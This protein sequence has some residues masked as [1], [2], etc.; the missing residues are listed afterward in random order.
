MVKH[1]ELKFVFLQGGDKGQGAQTYLGRP[2]QRGEEVDSNIFLEGHI[3]FKYSNIEENYLFQ[4]FK[5]FP[6]GKNFFPIFKY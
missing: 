3:S 2:R 5:Y 4:I 6:G 1:K